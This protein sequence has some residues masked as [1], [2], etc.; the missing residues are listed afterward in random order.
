MQTLYADTAVS[1]TELQHNPLAVLE[2]SEGEPVAILADNRAAAYLLPAEF[3]EKLMDALDDLALAELV[4]QRRG[5]AR[6]KVSFDE[7]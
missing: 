6:I 2:Q 1:L 7:L 5:Q 3:Y 4:E